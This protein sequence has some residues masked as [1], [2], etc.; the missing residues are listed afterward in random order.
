VSSLI[1]LCYD[2]PLHPKSGGAPRYCFEMAKRLVVRGFDVTWLSSRFPGSRSEE[3]WAGV[4]FVRAGSEYTTY[5]HSMIK[6]IGEDRGAFVFESISGVPYLTPL[7]ARGRT[8]SIVYHLVPFRTVAR[9]VGVAG[10]FVTVMQDI[11]TPLLYSSRPMITISQS[12]QL[13]LIARGFS[14]VQIVRMG[15]DLPQPGD[16]SIEGKEDVVVVTGPL[17]P[18]KRIEHCLAAFSILPA[19]WKLVVIG[20]FESEDYRQVLLNHA[21]RLNISGRTLFT[22]RISELSKHE[23][24]R[25]AKIALVASEKEGWGFNAMEPQTYGCPVIGYD[26]PGIRDSVRNGESGILVASGNIQ[27]LGQALLDLVNDGERCCLM[28]AKALSLYRDHTWDDVFEDFYRV[29]KTEL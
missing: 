26:V 8:L 12:T 15:A 25:K 21:H 24:Y 11:V 13:E 2:D 5:L 19:H 10:P 1:V 20:A 29:L 28:A 4:R 18:W 16:V 7:L 3:T 22:G 9:K 17:R 23:V 6:I 27:A 14:N